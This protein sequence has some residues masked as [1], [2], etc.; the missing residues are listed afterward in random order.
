MNCLKGSP[1]SRTKTVRKAKSSY[2]ISIQASS[3][4]S[5]ESEGHW[6]DVH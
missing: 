6:P 3:Q 4:Q 2:G 5:L 1:A